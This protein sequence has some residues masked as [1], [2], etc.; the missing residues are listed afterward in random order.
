[1]KV[2]GKILLKTISR[3]MSIIRETKS[4]SCCILNA[5]KQKK[6]KHFMMHGVY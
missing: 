3:V 4:D 6:T 2:N 1:M 5:K